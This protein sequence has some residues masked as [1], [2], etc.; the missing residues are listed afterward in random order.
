MKRFFLVLL[1]LGILLAGIIPA[2]AQDAPSGTFFGTWPYTLPPEHNLNAFAATGG[3]N[4][5]LGVIYRQMVEMPFAFYLWASD[6]WQPLLAES[7]GFTE[8]FSA[9]EVTINADAT[10]SNGSPVT[11][12][13]VVATYAIGRILGWSQFNS[14][15]DVAAVD[16]KTVR[17]TFID[18]PSKLAERLILKEYISSVATYGELAQKALDLIAAGKTSA[19]EEWSA[20]NTE[21]QEFR[22]TELL[23]SGPFTYTLDD[24]GDSF[25]TLKW[26]PNSIFSSNVKFGE[27]RLWAGETDSTT[28][29]V[30]DGSIA[31]S[32]NVYPPATQQAFVDAGIRLLIQPRM[33]GPAL[34]FNHDVHPWNIKEVRQAIAYIIDRDENA[35]LTNGLGATGTVYMAGL[36]D[37]SVPVMMN[38]DAIDQLNRYEFNVEAATALLEGIGFSKNADGKWL[39][40]DGNPVVGEYKYPA[41]FADFS[42]AA[43]NAVDQM[44]EFGF[45]IT[46]IAEPWQQTAEDIRA[47]NFQLSVWSWAGGSP[48]ASRQFFGP[49]QRFNYVSFTDGRKGMNFPMEFEYNGEMINLNDMINNANNGLDVEAQKANADK[50]ALIL[51][52]LMPFVPLNVILSTEPWNENLIQGGPADGDPILKNPSADHFVIWYMLQGLIA[53]AGS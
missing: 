50:I 16:D 19:D 14:I 39:D 24:V 37:D 38:Q 7:W 23:A 27:I 15:S 49:I 42:G 12:D 52:D 40:A 51:N 22:P 11:S 26:Q 29:L 10:W 25:M 17:F 21:I 8:D 9:Y 45:E 5:N 34:L 46:A 41:E 3:Q 13:D 4:T 43:L 32:T 18:Q 31:H 44:N 53:P 30:L 1:L 2:A 48:F 33:Y 36:L 47:G 28:P 6:E 20:L 35:F